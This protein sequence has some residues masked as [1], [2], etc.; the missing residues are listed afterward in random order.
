MH[1]PSNDENLQNNEKWVENTDEKHF[2]SAEEYAKR[3]SDLLKKINVSNTSEWYADSSFINPMT[4]IE[5]AKSSPM[6]AARWCQDA[7]YMLSSSH[8]KRMREYLVAAYSIAYELRNNEKEISELAAELKDGRAAEG[9]GIKPTKI[10]ENLLHYLFLFIFYQTG[11]TS[12]NRAS[13][14]AISLQIYFNEGR[15]PEKVADRIVAYG[16]E[17]LYRATGRYNHLIEGAKLYKAQEKSPASVSLDEILENMVSKN[18]KD[19]VPD[20]D[21][22]DLKYSTREFP[23]D[24]RSLEEIENEHLLSEALDEENDFEERSLTDNVDEPAIHAGVGVQEEDMP[25]D[26]T[27][28]D[29]LVQ[30]TNLAIQLGKDLAVENLN[31]EDRMKAVSAAI[32]LAR[33]ITSL[34]KLLNERKP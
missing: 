33:E 18:K 20:V 6:M 1:T 28:D 9:K 10:K 17:R 16:T 15:S 24:D 2:M 4:L 12:R 29:K 26:K 3:Q 31:R 14:Y 30:F 25:N 34:R 8:Q 23:D 32:Q 5:K 13:Q 27:I 22:S 11:L 19:I 7:C 21:S